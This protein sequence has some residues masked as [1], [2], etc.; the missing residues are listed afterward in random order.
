MPLYVPD[1]SGQL[2]ILSD[3]LTEDLIYVTRGFMSRLKRQVG[4]GG[5]GPG[6]SS[7]L[8]TMLLMRMV[9]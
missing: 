4:G 7:S 1:F 2:N 9:M 6:N 3:K 5:E 8:V